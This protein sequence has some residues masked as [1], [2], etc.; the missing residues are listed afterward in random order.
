[1]LW[2]FKNLAVYFE[3]VSSSLT[4]GYGVPQGS[5][6]GS[7]LFVVYIN[8]LPK[9]LLKSSVGM[10]TDDMV[11]YCSDSNADIIK[12]GSTKRSKQCRKMVREQQD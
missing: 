3:D 4:I 10:Y 6:L 11:M 5:I 12:Q 1:V 2:S 7:I 9:S 8:D